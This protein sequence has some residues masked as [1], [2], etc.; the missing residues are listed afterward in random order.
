[1]RTK[2]V[3]S[4]RRAFGIAAIGALAALAGA[5][6]A[7]AQQVANLEERQKLDAHLAVACPS[8]QHRNATALD[9]CRVRAATEFYNG[10]AAQERA[11]GAAADQRAAEADR[12]AA[13]ADRRGAKA[14]EDIKTM[15]VL[16]ECGNF[17]RDNRGKT[18]THEKM[19]ELAGGKITN[20]NICSVA[21]R[22][23]HV[24]PKAS[25]GTPTV[26]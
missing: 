12:R 16:Q 8:Q 7:S 10:L 1:M 5:D 14:D 22:L 19:L 15:S 18:F 21:K 25:L 24:P 3:P 9:R 23:G 20:D 6:R 11:R 4:V 17:L 13:A 26:R 2:T